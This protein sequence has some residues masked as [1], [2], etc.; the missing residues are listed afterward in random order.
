MPASAS[1]RVRV[2]VVG[3]GRLGTALLLSL[4]GAGCDIAEVVVRARTRKPRKVVQL[5]R[6]LGAKVVELGESPLA[7][8]LIWIAVPDGAIADVAA[9]LASQQEWRGRTV[10]H[11]SGALTSDA[12]QPL[13]AKG[14]R[15]ASVHPGMTFVA[16]SVP[17]LKGVPFG[18]EGDAAALRLARK[19]IA[20]VGG[21]AVTIRKENKVLYHAFD[22]FASPLLIG[23]MAAMENVGH[24]AGIPKKKLRTMAGPL[25]QQTLDNY[26][27]HG[28][29]AAFSGPFV[30]GDAAVVRKH[31]EALRKLPEA[32]AAY[33]ELA[34]AAGKHLQGKNRAEMAKLLRAAG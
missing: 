1:K 7:A 19:I 21:T 10:F 9:E 27:E 8:S 29:A 14:A 3:P 33:L 23:L 11:S 2:S 34:R 30:R 24:A 28:A 12:L 31:L 6:R 13:R 26:L 25:L 17:S 5:G 4:A 18:I 16:K 20:D 15:V 22:T 32:R